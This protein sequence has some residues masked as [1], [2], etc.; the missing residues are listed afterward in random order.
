M[1]IDYEKLG[2]K[3]GIEA[4]QQLEGNKL[5]CSCPTT[6]SRKGDDIQ[7]FRKL[8]AVIGETGEVDKAAAFEMAKAKTYHYVGNREESCLVEIDEEPPHSIN[9]EAVKTALIIA[10]LLNAKVVDEIQVMRKTVVDGSNTTGFQRTALVAM[11]GYVETPKGKVGIESICLEEEACQKVKD[12]DALLMSQGIAKA[13]GRY[14]DTRPQASRIRCNSRPQTIVVGFVPECRV[15]P[16]CTRHEQ[17]ITRRQS[18]HRWHRH[19]IRY[20]LA[21]THNTKSQ[22]RTRHRRITRSGDRTRPVGPGSTQFIVGQ[23]R[24]TESR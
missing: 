7:I 3:C 5:F 24:H 8:R 13:I 11:N 16:C 19:F 2:F 21:A 23:S 4:H 14:R 18:R 17:S 20:T 22:R 6:N 1:D 10:K 9:P 15:Q 12:D